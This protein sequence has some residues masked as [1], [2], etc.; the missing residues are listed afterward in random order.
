[1]SLVWGGGESSTR[2]QIILSVVKK[3]LFSLL[4]AL[5]PLSHVSLSSH[6]PPACIYIYIPYLFSFF[7]SFFGNVAEARSVA[8]R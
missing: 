1:M 5:V 4:V 8:A 2:V 3:Q 7:V 6:T